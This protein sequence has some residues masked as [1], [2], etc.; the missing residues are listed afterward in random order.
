MKR[1]LVARLT[2][3]G[4]PEHA[5]EMLQGDPALWLPKPVATQAAGRWQVYLWAGEV[6]VL[7]DCALGE[8]WGDQPTLSRLLRWEPDPDREGGRIARSVPRFEGD[9]RFTVEGPDSGVLTVDGHYTPPGGLLGGLLD[10]LGL[11]RVARHTAD[12]FLAD[13]ARQLRDGQSTQGRH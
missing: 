6:G 1:A 10:A 11:W 12:Q 8:A 2:V 7:V 9:I 4:D 13:V 3:P 5:L